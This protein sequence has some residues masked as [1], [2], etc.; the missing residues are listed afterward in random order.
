VSAL[1]PQLLDDSPAGRWWRSLLSRL[2]SLV[3]EGALAAEEM[4]QFRAGLA[5]ENLLRGNPAFVSIE[6][7]SGPADDIT[8]FLLTRDGVDLESE[9]DRSIRAATRVLEESLKTQTGADVH[10]DMV[11]LWRLTSELMEIIDRAVNPAPHAEL[12]HSSWGAVS[13]AVERISTS[14]TYD[15]AV[16]GHPDLDALLALISRIGRSPYP[17]ERGDDDD[18]G[19]MGWGN[20]DVR[21]YAA[22]SAMRL[23]QRF[24]GDRPGIL[25]E[26]E[27]F[28]RDPVPTVR[29]QV[30]QSINGLWDVARDRMWSLAD[31]VAKN[32]TS[33]DVNGG[34]KVGQR[35]VAKPGHF[36]AWA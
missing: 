14:D 6:T 23:A 19:M 20:W 25:D 21:V 17:E 26:L 35:G 15:R 28:V 7:R 2:L 33:T 13:N 16:V 24:A 10:V 8:D 11:S 1:Q 5:T 12:L 27:T 34:V 36:A 22:S 32:E 29:L 30:A 3:P 4:S 31:Y 9:P 18:G